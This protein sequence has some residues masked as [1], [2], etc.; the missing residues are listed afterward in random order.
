[1]CLCAHFY[2]FFIFYSDICLCVSFLFYLVSFFPGMGSAFHMLCMCPRYSKSLIPHCHTFIMGYGK[3]LGIYFFHSFIHYL[4]YLFL[5]CY[6]FSFI[7]VSLSLAHFFPL[8]IPYTFSTTYLL[9]SVVCILE[10]RA[11]NSRFFTDYLDH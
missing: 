6:L 7:F 5:K 8:L 1:M 2:F 4:L 9:I 3:L 10:I 11:S